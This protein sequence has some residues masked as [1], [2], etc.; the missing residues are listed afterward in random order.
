[1]I[2]RYANAMDLQY[3]FEHD[4]HIA[5]EML[6]NKIERKEIILVTDAGHMICGWLRY[7]Y[8][9]DN[10]PFM[11][12]LYINEKYRGQGIGR[13]LVEF[14]ENAMI[15][16]GFDIV[17]TSTLSNERAQ[18]FYR[19]LGY[20]DAGSLLLEN[21]PLEIIFTKKLNS[22]FNNSITHIKEF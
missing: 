11:N 18:D 17:M 10:T 19:G 9:W 22:N 4:K 16:K 5:K 12:M 1:M 14:W 13:E 8:F 3:L 7:G 6:E 21:E 2:I 20:K 15:S